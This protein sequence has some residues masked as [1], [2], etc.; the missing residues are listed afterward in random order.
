MIGGRLLMTGFA[1]PLLFAAV[2]GA[3]AP[4]DSA[5]AAVMH[6]PVAFAKRTFATAAQ[7]PAP[8]AFALDDTGAVYT[9][10]ALRYDG[11]GIFDVR[12]Y[13]NLQGDLRIRSL[14]ERRVATEQWVRS[15]LL[16]T[17]ERKVTLRELA[18]HAD[19][20]RRLEDR[21]GDGR[22]DRVT[23]IA[24]GMNDL[25]QGAAA[26]VLP[27][28]GR[29]YATVIPDLWELRDST[30]NGDWTRRSLQYGFGVH[31]GQ[32][33]HDLHGLV[34][35]LDGW[36]YWSVG[37]RGFDLVTREGRHLVGHT[38]AVFRCWPDGTGLEVFARGLRNPQELA[39][40]DEGDLFTGDNNAD[41]GDRSRLLYLP[42][43]G[44]GGWTYY[45]QFR[46][47][48]GPWTSER[49]WEKPGDVAASGASGASGAFGDAVQPTWTLPTLDY[50]GTCP[51]GFTA[52]PGTGLPH[53]YD[54]TLWLADFLGGVQAFRVT[55]EGAG[56][57]MR[58]WHWAWRDGW[59]INDFDFGPDGRA[60]ALHWGESWGIDDGAR[61]DVLTPPAA[62]VDTAL[63][64]EVRQ[65]LRAGF[66]P[67]DVAALRA[68][69][70][71]ADR[72]LRQRAS[73]ELARR[74]AVA[75]LADVAAHDA[76]PLARRHALWALGVIAHAR[77]AAVVAPHV[78]L[79]LADADPEVRR[80]AATVA[81]ELGAAAA[82][83]RLVPLLADDAPR[84]RFAAA[85]ALAALRGRATA[86][87]VHALAENADA[88]R[89]LRFAYARA[90]AAGTPADTLAAFASHANRAVRL[91]A[92]L[93]LREARSE[94]VAAFLDDADTQVA[95]EAARA[96]YDLDLPLARRAL[97]LRLPAL[98][99]DLRT[100]AVALRALHAA[101]NGGGAAEARA[102]AAFAADSAT[103][104]PWRT[105][106]LVVLSTWD[107]PSDFDGVWGRLRTPAPREPGNARAAIAAVLPVVLDRARG[108]D[109]AVALELARRHNLT[110]SNTQLARWAGDEALDTA[111]RVHALRWLAARGAPEAPAALA[112]ALAGRDD[113]LFVAAYALRLAADPAATI[114]SARRTFT[115]PAVPLAVRQ[116]A[117]R[118]LGATAA[119]AAQAFVQQRLAEL[120][121][122]AVDS[123]LALDLAEAGRRAGTAWAGLPPADPEALPTLWPLLH[124]GDATRGQRVFETH[125]A[126]QCVRCHAV[127][128]VGGDVGPDL[129][130]IGAHD[131]TYLLQ[132][133]VQ[134]NAQLAP[135]Y[136]TL[137]LTLRD[138]SEVTGML[139]DSTAAALRLRTDGGERRVPRDSIVARSVAASVMPPMFGTLTPHELR[140]VIAWLAT[141]REDVPGVP[142]PGDAGVTPR[143]AGRTFASG[144]RMGANQRR[145][146]AVPA[147]ALAFVAVCGVDDASPGGQVGFAV[148]V[149]GRTLWRSGARRH[150]ALARVHVP[151][152]PGARVLELVVD[153]GGN[154]TANDVAG[155]AAAGWQL[156]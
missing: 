74:G 113:S 43:G 49:M 131:R 153:D 5:A 79:A 141:R 145:T 123:S 92:L 84:V 33:G 96:A 108:E 142:L 122:G 137:A 107:A 102:V 139:R 105:E 32:A 15:G 154:G 111:T 95:T 60:W 50:L 34:M 55:P 147:G 109:L 150:G 4:G 35:G 100:E 11:H 118:A 31:M 116:A 144:L 51:S 19:Q 17:P 22:A 37:D 89:L 27:W 3:S 117:I 115:S 81:G 28:G 124:G 70:A 136:G 103:S 75:E 148:R 45:Q 156:R 10:N 2:T 39:F 80:V 125:A 66:T 56:F 133:L 41:V 21:D 47:G 155:W 134:P 12:A 63:V 114:A 42:M 58:D 7:L 83:P 140:D 90:L 72:R 132:A 94:R 128:G 106:A 104:E 82:V 59:G 146:F 130:M 135:G 68:L 24:D 20:V 48:C 127:D 29:V 120:A 77:G 61:L 26:G 67:L 91:G 16:D 121:R 97:A 36:L 54:G 8:V 25:L 64:S 14:R 99:A 78:L 101:A 98:R 30:G 126:A 44:D 13:P 57:A 138:A 6:A 149:D 52:Y 110:L 53:T 93:A 152:P 65:R 38:G 76:R 23:A 88:D 143:L 86:A 71:H 151:L 46:R 1:L 119:P 112:A 18:G 62:G 129:G 40:T 69:L 87:L 73:F 9:A 85:Q